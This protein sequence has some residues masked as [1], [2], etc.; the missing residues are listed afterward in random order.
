[1]ISHLTFLLA[2]ALLVR[3]VYINCKLTKAAAFDIVASSLLFLFLLYRILF[4]VTVEP[5]WFA[6]FTVIGMSCA[7]LERFCVGYA[8]HCNTVIEEWHESFHEQLRRR[9]VTRA[10]LFW[11]HLSELVSYVVLFSVYY[12]FWYM[13]PF[14]VPDGLLYGWWIGLVFEHY[15]GAEFRLHVQYADGKRWDDSMFQRFYHNIETYYW[16]HLLINRQRCLGFSTPFWDTLF[17]RN[18]FLSRCRFSTPLPFVDFLFVD[19]ETDYD[20]VRRH[21]AHYQSKFI[22]KGR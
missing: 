6:V 4:V 20:Q 8:F 15:V 13:L 22:N 9:K 19:Y 2:I 17:G 14:G 12:G 21:L 18:P 7:S 3:R 11:D 10:Y 16:Y 1:M 5:V